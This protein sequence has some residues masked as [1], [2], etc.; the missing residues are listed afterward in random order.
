MN[1]E[2]ESLR[3]QRGGELDQGGGEQEMEDAKSK[4]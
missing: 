2:G 4:N 1:H 3:L